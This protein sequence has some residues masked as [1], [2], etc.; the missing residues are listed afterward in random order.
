ME[1]S[2]KPFLDQVIK[3]LT[4]VASWGFR[5]PLTLCDEKGMS[6][7]WYSSPKTHNHRIILRK[8]IR[9]TQIEDHSRNFLASTPQ[10]VKVTRNK[11]RQK[12]SQT[13]G[14]RIHGN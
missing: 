11:A 6:P 13:R 10:N 7:L 8:Y 2:G 4:S 12:L 14:D 5:D 9:Q 1:K 3:V